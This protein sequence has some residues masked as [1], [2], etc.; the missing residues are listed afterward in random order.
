MS[1]ALLSRHLAAA[2][3]TLASAAFAPQALAVETTP[4]SVCQPNKPCYGPLDR[5]IDRLLG[6]L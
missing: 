1:N 5:L 4:D 6:G 3:L 2:V